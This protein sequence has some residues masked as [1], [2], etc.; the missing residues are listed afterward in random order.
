V[1]GITV[2][3]LESRRIRSDLIETYKIMTAVY[4]IPREIFLECDNSGL[5]GHERKLFNK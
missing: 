3:R 4:N 1:F 5:R 2:T